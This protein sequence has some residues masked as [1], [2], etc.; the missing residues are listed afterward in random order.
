MQ[1]R[2]ERLTTARSYIQKARRLLTQAEAITMKARTGV[3]DRETLDADHTALD[4]LMSGEEQL[5]E[6]DYYYGRLLKNGGHRG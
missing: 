5:T 2:I 1:K 4:R 6:A 3:T